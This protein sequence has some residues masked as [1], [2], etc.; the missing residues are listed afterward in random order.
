MNNVNYGKLANG[1]LTFAPLNLIIGEEQVLNATAEEYLAAGWL[2]IEYTQKPD[3]GEWQAVYTEIDGKILQSW[4]YQGKVHDHTNLDILNNVSEKSLSGMPVVHTLPTDAKDG[5]VC[6]YSPANVLTLEDS[7]KRIYFDW[8]NVLNSPE[9]QCRIAYVAGASD[10][11]IVSRLQMSFNKASM[12][13]FTCSIN[14]QRG[15]D[16]TILSVNIAPNG[17]VNGS[18][19]T[20][21]NGEQQSIQ[22]KSI[23]D[24]PLYLDLP[25]ID[26]I[27]TSQVTGD[28]NAFYTDYSLMCYRVGEWQNAVDAGLTEEQLADIKANV[29]ARHEH[30]NKDILD[31]ITIETFKGR[32]PAV[33]ELPTDATDGDLC[34]YAPANT[35]TVEDSGKRI[36]FDWENIKHYSASDNSP[37]YVFYLDGSEV[38]RIEISGQLC[39]YTF[40]RKIDDESTQVLYVNFD[41]NNGDF[42]DGTLGVSYQNGAGSGRDLRNI[43]DVPL[44]WELP[45]FTTIAVIPPSTTDAF[46]FY[47]QY[48]LMVYQGGEWVKLEKDFYTKQEIDAKGFI[49]ADDIPQSGG[50]PVVHGL[51]TDAQDGDMCLYSP[52]NT[53]EPSDSGKRIY[54]DWEEIITFITENL[55]AGEQAWIQTFKNN[56][57][58]FKIEQHY[59]AVSISD[60]LDFTY[61]SE[62]KY[63][64]LII[65]FENGDFKTATKKF[66]GVPEKNDIIYSS[67]DELPKY[68]DISEFDEVVYDG[69]VCG[70]YAP[71]RLM[72]Y[73]GGE[74]QRVETLLNIDGGS[75][76]LTDYYTK[77][78]I[79]NKGFVTEDDLPDGGVYVG[80]G[81]MPENCNV[82]IDPD[83]DIVIIPTKTS[84]LIND[85]G[86][87]TESGMRPVYELPANAKDGDTCLY[88]PTNVI[89]LND[90]GKRI[91]F[92][93]EEITKVTEQHASIQVN[94]F[95]STGL[96]QFDL[97]YQRYQDV[98]E[99]QISRQREADGFGIAISV[100]SDGHCGGTMWWYEGEEQYD[101]EVMSID[102]LPEYFD[103]PVFDYM[104]GFSE[105]D[106]YCFHKS[107]RLMV[108][109][110]DEWHNAEDM[111]EIDTVTNK[112]E[113][114][115][116]VT[117]YV[118]ILKPNTYYSL[119]EVTQI[120]VDF[121]EGAEDKRNEY[122][123]SFTS[124]ETPT[125]VHLP[126][127]VQWMNELTVEANKRYEISVVDNI[128]LWCAVD[129]AV[130]E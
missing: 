110:N 12:S 77:Q 65:E 10:N 108:Y 83:G 98:A 123:F 80:L 118:G 48:N 94:A 128:G 28:F 34:L 104:E 3:D 68:V 124:G 69:K 41:P 130:S 100:Y 32:V 45:T 82:Q 78:E 5:D 115:A 16:A 79:D 61:T 46:L 21:V 31:D 86:F 64:E 15:A 30:A 33:H 13:S 19:R 29:A 116:I 1:V 105:G 74:W 129:L 102:E 9:T 114:S 127:S 51:P 23:S 54:F 25:K 38:G 111:V 47:T 93:W 26:N 109:H 117:D 8:E 72:V 126:S 106:A 67:I 103:I 87:V 60:T 89:T 88:F 18:F 85:S 81:E 91:Y 39:D 107:P 42:I 36:Y 71:Y 50:I 66:V 43:E 75:V 119:G 76:D 92:D 20:V 49:T 121:R 63:Y 113:A 27:T 120:A 14:M 125:I 99:I 37:I 97:M 101:K 96:S 2:Q 58:G 44:Y 7:G 84:E 70:V 122:M 112:I 22:L 73:R 90:S 6:L 55:S 35:V 57:L 53:I 62:D 24:I 4:V 11:G 95:L 17:T 40:H 52:A 59:D 56:L